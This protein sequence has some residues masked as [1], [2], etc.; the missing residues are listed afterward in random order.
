MINNG[1]S[2]IKSY[3]F[4]AKTMTINSQKTPHTS[5]LPAN[6]APFLCKIC[7]MIS[8]VQGLILW[9]CNG[10][11]TFLFSYRCNWFSTLCG[12]WYSHLTNIC[13]YKRFQ[14]I[15][16]WHT[17]MGH[18]DTCDEQGMKRFNTRLCSVWIP[19]S[20]MRR[21]YPSASIRVWIFCVIHQWR[22]F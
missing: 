6:S 19:L 20:H 11:N 9:F 2:K 3:W 4:K 13:R 18:I 7:R 5:P 21:R 1:S 8:R 22:R 16:I 14:M 12:W 15:R 10:I 17:K